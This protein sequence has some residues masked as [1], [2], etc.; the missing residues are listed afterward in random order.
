MN[1]QTLIAMTLTFALL[2]CSSEPVDSKLTTAHPAH[3]DAR[4]ADGKAIPATKDQAADGA[5]EKAVPYPLTVCLVGGEELGSM[6]K[7]YGFVHEGRQ[8]MLCCKAC[9]KEFKSD[10]AKFVKKFDDAV[11]AKHNH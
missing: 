8:I 7:P 4:Q 11:K 2:S 6:G 9:E 3:A 5:K 10:T 1:T